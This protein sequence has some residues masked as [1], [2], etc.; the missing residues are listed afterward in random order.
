VQNETPDEV[1]A[2]TWRFLST[3]G[4]GTF[5][6]LVFLPPRAGLSGVFIAVPHILTVNPFVYFGALETQESPDAMDWQPALFD[7]PVDGIGADP[8]VY[9]DLLH[10]SP[11]VVHDKLLCLELR[12]KA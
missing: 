9:R 8:Q 12:S 4:R 10:A 11:A 1:Q 6:R 7:P 3:A 5:L 2:A